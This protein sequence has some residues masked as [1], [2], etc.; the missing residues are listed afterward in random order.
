MRIVCYTD[1]A[2]KGNPGIGGW[3][4]VAYTDGITF[5]SWGGE[6]KT[7][8]QQMELKAI[9]D[10]LRGVLSSGIT[11]NTF[12]EIWTDSKYAYGGIVNEHIPKGI[13]KSEQYV[14]DS[15][16]QGW[17][18]GWT[19]VTGKSEHTNSYWKKKDLKNKELWYSIHQ[20]LLEMSRKGVNVSIGWVK[21]HN[22]DPGNEVADKLANNY[23]MNRQFKP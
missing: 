22:D 9:M 20:S 2:C 13:L 1:G 3:G 15:I 6:G 4:W 16:P 11:K 17:L 10:L 23:P 18:R 8:N 14:I 7:T 19:N 5:Y 12:V 21:G